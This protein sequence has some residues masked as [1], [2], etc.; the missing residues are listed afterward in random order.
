[1]QFH[2][3]DFL[4]FFPVVVLLFYGMPRRLRQVWLL[5]ASYYFYMGWNA[6]Y[7]L[8]IFAVTVITYLCAVLIERVGT[9]DD[10]HMRKRK[11]VLAVGIVSNL[12]V[13]VFF[14]YFYFLHDMSAALFNVFGVKLGE[15]RLEILLPVGISFYTFQALGYTI[16]VYRGTV[17]A[18]KNFVRYALFVSFFP[19]LVA[20]PIERSGNL[21]GQLRQISDKKLSEG[22]WSFEKATR[23]LLLMLWGFFMK[24]VIA[25]RAAVLVN[26]VFDIYYMFSGVALTLAGILFVIQLYCDFASYSA[27]A[28]GAAKVLGIDLMTNFEAPFFSRSVGEFWRRWHV[29]LSSWFRDYLYIPLGGNRCS[30]TRK[31][32]NTMVTFVVS[33]LWHGASWHFVVWGALQGVYLVTGELTRPLKTKCINFFHVRVKTFGYQFFQG[34]CTFCLIT[35]SF[36]FFR[37]NTVADAFYYIQRLFTTFDIWSLFDGSIYYLGLD[38]KEMGVL[39]L[40]ILILILVDTYYVR[41][42]VLFDVM[43][44]GQC[45]AVQYGIVAVLLVMILVFGVYGEGY[46]ASQFIY[47]QF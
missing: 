9:Q 40:G 8:L 43:V 26:Q 46:D 25:D 2:S 6:K 30:K 23:G 22:P 11:I 28:M 33:G 5:L 4:V 37:A 47:F 39:G 12:A 7:A 44:K 20:G 17:K 19:Q 3:F 34:A 32:L 31:Y 1:M 36:V 21:L 15:P 41:K 18:E 27:I 42:K 35:L 45:L 14:K 16:D 13:L 10:R 24:M 29:S 38:R